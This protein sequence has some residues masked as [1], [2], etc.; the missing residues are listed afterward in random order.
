MFRFR[1][2]GIIDGGNSEQK[3]YIIKQLI[4]ILFLAMKKKYPTKHGKYFP[5]MNRKNGNYYKV[6]LCVCEYECVFVRM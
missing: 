2:A 4:K 1:G 6:N 5:C 3:I